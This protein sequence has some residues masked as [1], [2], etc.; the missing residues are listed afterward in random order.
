LNTA[1]KYFLLLP[2]AIDLCKNSITFDSAVYKNVPLLFYELL[3]E[4]LA[5]F[6]NFWHATLK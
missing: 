3:G 4:T 2:L 5:D 1:V 6:N